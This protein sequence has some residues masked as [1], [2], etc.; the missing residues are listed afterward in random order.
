MFDIW[1]GGFISAML[2][3]ELEDVR[4]PDVTPEIAEAM[5]VLYGIAKSRI[6]LDFKILASLLHRG[7]EDA[8]GRKIVVILGLEEEDGNLRIT[9][10]ARHERLNFRR[11][12]PTLSRTG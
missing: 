12:C 11:I 2:I 6:N 3:E 10:G 1:L 7:G 9:D 8:A 4:S 5:A